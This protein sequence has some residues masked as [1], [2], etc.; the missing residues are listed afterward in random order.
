MYF[1]SIITFDT[2]TSLVDAIDLEI[3]LEIKV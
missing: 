1:D 2:K 3:N